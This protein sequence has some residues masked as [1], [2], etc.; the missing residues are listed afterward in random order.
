MKFVP[1]A[2]LIPLTDPVI[3]NSPPCQHSLRSLIIGACGSTREYTYQRDAYEKVV[4]P[5]S[6]HDPESCVEPKSH[7]GPRQNLTG[8]SVSASLYGWWEA[9]RAHTM[10]GTSVPTKSDLRFGHD[11]LSSE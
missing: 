4:P 7:G 6:P 2:K 5:G 10:K 1:V 11:S 3:F 8:I 9:G